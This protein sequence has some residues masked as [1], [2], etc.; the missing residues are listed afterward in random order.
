MS[1][2][3]IHGMTVQ[4]ECK[5]DAAKEGESNLKFRCNF[6]NAIY[7]PLDK[8]LSYY[9]PIDSKVKSQSNFW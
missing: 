4:G 5:V 1:E 3:Y 2:F 8:N 6:L 9:Y 7:L